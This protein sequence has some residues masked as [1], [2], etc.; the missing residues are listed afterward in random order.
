[1]KRAKTRKPES[2]IAR[3]YRAVQDQG[4]LVSSYATIKDTDLHIL[5][6]RE[7]S[8]VAQELALRYRLQIEKYIE[9]CPEFARAL[10]PLPADVLA[11]PIV[12]E[13]LAAGSAAGVGPMAAVAGVIAEYVGRGLVHS[14][15]LEVMVEN[16]GDIYIHRN[17]DCTVAIFA[18]E[19]PLSLR[20]GVKLAGQTMPMAVCTSSGT[21]GHSLS[22]GLA[23][24]VTV[25]ARSAALAD[26]AATRLG[27]EI[28]RSPSGLGMKK[29]LEKSRDIDGVLGVVVIC[30]EKIGAVGDVE[31]VNIH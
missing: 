2:Y 22:L 4:D 20:V 16:G 13:M 12:R 28:G 10:V 1:M 27:N 11:P 15:C 7:V 5:A 26:A 9:K 30:R 21:V 31:L 29:A 24:S 23:D 14:G 25:L 19:S 3:E 18:G 8:S 17:R 6:D